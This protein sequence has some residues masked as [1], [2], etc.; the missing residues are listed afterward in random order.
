[1]RG[2]GLHSVPDSNRTGNPTWTICFAGTFP[3]ERGLRRDFHRLFGA[4]ADR[5]HRPV[6][7][8][9]AIPL[10]RSAP[11]SPRK[12][13]DHAGVT[14]VTPRTVRGQSMKPV[15][16][17]NATLTRRTLRRVWDELG[18]PQPEIVM[19][20][21]P[22][23]QFVWEVFP[24]GLR[25]WRNYDYQ[26]LEEAVALAAGA[27]L[28]LTT[29][30]RYVRMGTFPRGKTRLLPNT[31]DEISDLAGPRHPLGVGEEPVVG[32]MGTF[33]HV[34]LGLLRSVIEG[35]PGTR[36]LFQGI[37]GPDAAAQLRHERVTLVPRSDSEPAAVRFFL[38][39]VR[40]GLCPYE[41]SEWQLHSSPDRLLAFL[42]AGLPVVT[43]DFSEDALAPF[44]DLPGVFVAHDAQ[45]F[46]TMIPVAV[47]AGQDPA[48]VQGLVD[49][50]EPYLATNLAPRFEE[51]VAEALS[52][53][54]ETDGGRSA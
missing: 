19:I 6:Y 34:D 48:V 35:S 2:R 9:P 10:G 14:L 13:S 17:V 27:D 45:A 28:I 40:V 8:E 54:A 39:S 41:Q 1:M 25:V 46:R 43:T 18:L 51:L 24:A 11:P 52:I 37:I 20:Q 32:T 7:I 31:C 5:G 36:F 12:A 50:A 3:W 44:R 4:L 26:D 15:A 49:A 53:R 29:S 22:Y 30:P 42:R 47:D 16:A 23:R 38:R 21:P 33:A